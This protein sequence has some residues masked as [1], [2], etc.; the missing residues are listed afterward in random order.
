MDSRLLQYYNAELQYIRGMGAEF[1]KA[2]PKIARRLDLDEFECADPYVERLLEGFA[3]LAARVQL[4]MDDEF[5]RL[6]QHLMDMLYP[7]YLA[8]IPSMMV[9]RFE[10]D[11]ESGDLDEGFSLPRGTQ[12]Q[13]RIGENE[14]TACQYRTSHDVKL[15]PLEIETA[16]YFSQEST[17]VSFPPDVPSSKSGV[18]IQLNC[19]SGSLSELNCEELDFY[20]SGNL[21]SATHLYEQFFSNCIAIGLRDQVND[22]W[23]GW[24]PA[25]NCIEPIGFRDEESLLPCDIRSFQG[26]RLLRE[27]FSFHQRFH[28]F[29]LLG[30][31]RLIS[32]CSGSKA[33]LYLL[34]DRV[35]RNLESKVDASNFS[36]NCVP[37]VNLFEQR[38]ERV[39]VTPEKKEFH[40]VPDRVRPMDLEVFSVQSVMGIGEGA[41]PQEEFLPFY[42]F[43]HNLKDEAGSNASYYTLRRTPRIASNRQRR[44]GYRTS[45]LGSEC[46]ITL[47]DGHEQPFD[48]NVEQLDVKLLC[49]NRD[50]PLNMNLSSGGTDFTI[51]VGAPV[52]AVRVVAGPTAPQESLANRPGDL[53]W[54]L[55][56]HMSLNY[57]SIVEGENN[58]GAAAL[59]GLLKLYGNSNDASIQRQIDGVRSIDSKM[60]TRRMPVPGPISFGRGVEISLL[61]DEEHFQGYGPYLMGAV[62]SRFFERFAAINSFTET[63]LLTDKRNEVTRW[64]AVIGNR[65]VL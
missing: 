64:P 16:S 14:Q 62:L 30:L 20:L 52:R 29:R 47:V 19:R 38:G 42:S 44:L 15:W 33:E 55:V 26:Y 8:Q 49:T 65:K 4:K 36:L 56:N 22:Q 43:R 40:I 60:V 53:Q 9:V 45:Y 13:S 48:P 11:F 1:A 25:A 34:F 61:L 23:T 18:R 57:L 50:L 37:A 32:R 46:F 28:F 21:D 59:R 17:H 63:V 10:P 2:Y 35:D 12:L 6:T 24:L 58:R 41:A 27:Y 3:F 31:K 54:R 51:Q 5:P 39:I 7:D